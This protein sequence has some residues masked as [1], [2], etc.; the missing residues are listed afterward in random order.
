MKLRTVLLTSVLGLSACNSTGCAA[1]RRAVINLFTPE[2]EPPRDPQRLTPVFEGPDAA[3]ER[4]AVG[5]VRVADGVTQPTDVQF[6]PGG[7]MVVL[8]KEGRAWWFKDGARSV[9]TDVKVATDSEEGLLGLAFHPRYA[10]NGRFYL[11]YV[12]REDGDDFTII[13]AY[14][15]EP[16]RPE[17]AARLREVVLK[18]AQPYSNHNA[19]QLAFGP[20]GMLYAGFGDGGWAGD[21]KDNGQNPATLLGKMLRIDVDRKDPGLAYA[22]PQDN[23]FVGQPGHRPEIWALGLRNPW[24]YAFDAQ[25][26]LIVADVGQDKWEEIDW[27]VR[28]GNYGWDEREGRH[29]HEPAT[30][31]QSGFAEPIYEYGRDDGSS[32]TG[33]YVYEGP[34]IAALRGKYVFGDFLSG[35]L[36]AVDVPAEPGAAVHRAFTLGGWPVLVSSF[37]RDGAGELYVASFAPGAVYK[38]VPAQ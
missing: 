19:G 7:A 27:V 15:M 2:Y 14:E 31:C 24:R 25:G 17:S 37:G 3:R 26:R 34:A 32:I 4:I 36:W 30:G 23:P 13:A 20:D 21:P 22:V 10:E 1:A 5:L 35:K 38:I 18:V 9:L 33:G 12:V 29:C 28:G 6:S 11:N 8:E 16:E